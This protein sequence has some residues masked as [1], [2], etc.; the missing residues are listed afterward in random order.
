VTP[1]RALAALLIAVG[2]W[3]MAPA[4]RSEPYLAV[5]Q[6]YK[7]ITC[8]VNPTG[9]GLRSG[10]GTVFTE[11]VLPESAA[12]AKWP[13]WT[14][15]VLKILRVGAD[16]RTARIDTDVPKQPSF[17]QDG[18]EQLRAYGDLTLIP[19]WLEYYVDETLAP[20]KDQANEY[21]ARLSEP[22]LGLY[23]KGGQF[24]LPFGWRLQ[25]NTA[26][27][28]ELSGISMTAPDRGFELGLELPEW[29]AQ[30]DYT[31]GEANIALGKGHELTG[32]VV[33]VKPSWRIGA[34]AA[35]TQSVFGNRQV[36]GLFAGLKT[37]PVAWLGELDLVRDAGYPGGGRRLAALFGEADWALRKGHNLKV[38]AEM[39]DPDR[40][41]AN[42]Q[43]A[44]WSVLYEYTPIPFVQ[45]RGGFRRYRGIPQID[46]DNRHVLFIELHVFL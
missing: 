14:G 18:L 39:F 32:Q 37:G 46:V 28:R 45:L 30:I 24:Y 35:Y 31:R 13:T 25:D 38:T 26:L 23:V 11:N 8:H 27:V 21:Y 43:Q 17:R 5:Q 15:E 42:D 34:S 1:R 19:K 41:V 22:D 4:A 12:P 36:E 44:R 7:C 40:S 6:G 3:G 10:F 29:S 9:G 33:Y 16:Y 20:G 2:C